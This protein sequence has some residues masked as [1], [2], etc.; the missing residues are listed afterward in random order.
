MSSGASLPL[1][2]STSSSIRNMG[3]KQS[4]TFEFESVLLRMDS[5]MKQHF[6]PLPPEV[7]KAFEEAGVRRIILSAAGKSWRRAIMNTKDGDR[8]IFMGQPILRELGLK[9]GQRIRVGL[10]PDPEPDAID[11]GEEFEAVLDQDPQ[12]AE[13][14]FSFTPGTQRSLAYYVTS[15]KR[16]ETRIKRALELAHKIKTR[17]LHMDRER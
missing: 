7:A 17:S 14:F 11:L 15:A 13:R 2:D 3:K 12:A 9:A 10:E 4:L 8:H 6:L 1:S 16:V 5:S